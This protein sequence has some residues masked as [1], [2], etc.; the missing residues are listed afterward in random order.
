M[1]RF[2]CDGQGLSGELSCMQI[3]LVLLQNDPRY[4]YLYQSCVIVP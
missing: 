2:L 4:M 1:L 3:R